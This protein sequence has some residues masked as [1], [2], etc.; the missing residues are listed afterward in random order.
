MEEPERLLKEVFKIPYM[1]PFQELVV[2]R[3]LDDMEDQCDEKNS[4]TVFPTGAGKSLCFML[5]ALLT[6]DRYTILLYPLLSLMNDQ[7]RRFDELEVESTLIRGGMEKDERSKAIENLKSFKSHILI[8]NM[9]SLWYMFL[10][11][12]TLIFREKTELFVLDEAHT[13]VT[14]GETFRKSYE[15]LSLVLDEIKPHQRLSFSAT[16]DER[17]ETRLRETIYKDRSPVVLRLSSDRENIHYHVIYSLSKLM[18]IVNILNP[19]ESRPALIFTRYRSQTKELSM[20]LSNRFRAYHYHA[21]LDKDEKKRIENEFYASGD[22]VMVATSAYGMGVDKKNIR[23]VIHYSVPD[24]ALS[25]LQESG[26]GGRDRK[27]MDSY[28]LIAPGEKGKLLSVFTSNECIRNS[29]L[30]LMGEN[31]STG[32]CLGCSKCLNEDERGRGWAEITQAVRIP[33][34]HTKRSLSLYLKMRKLRDWNIGEISKAID[35]A[36]KFKV[37]KVVFSR[38]MKERGPK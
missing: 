5:P 26:R 1:M 31:V 24:D 23:T 15:N 9:E 2:K 34:L 20:K 33:F 21:G 30:S 22:A 12:E 37:I 10:R 4:M 35:S 25:F 29:L 14:W 6:K 11:D 16:I 19:P 36:E 13:I 3:I 38:I 8:T 32:G 7:K 27:R 28:I 17:I 18:D